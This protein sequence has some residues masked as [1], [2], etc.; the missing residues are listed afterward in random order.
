MNRYNTIQSGGLD[1]PCGTWGGSRFLQCQPLSC[2]NPIVLGTSS[3]L[4]AYVSTSLHLFEDD[5]IKLNSGLLRESKSINQ[6][7][8]IHLFITKTTYHI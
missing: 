3:V 6:S 7:I 2:L 1:V 4:S 8:N 5:F